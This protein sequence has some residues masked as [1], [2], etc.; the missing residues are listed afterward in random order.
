[1]TIEEENKELVRRHFEYQNRRQGDA[2]YEL[3]SPELVFHMPN[4]DMSVKQGREFDAMLMTA[5]PDITFTIE[6]II[7]EGDKVAFRV[8]LKGTHLGEFMGHAP[9]GKKIE[10]TNSNWFRVSDGK[11]VEFWATSDRF[12]LMQQ[13]GL[14]STEI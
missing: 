6:D 2:A 13:L 12:R 5:F 8:T 1:M 4:G 9:T 11:L 10:I 7:A 14:I 3:I